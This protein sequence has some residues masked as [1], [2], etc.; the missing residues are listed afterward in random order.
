MNAQ[1]GIYCITHRASGKRYVGQAVD[2]HRRT[3]RHKNPKR[4]NHHAIGLAVLKY[5]ADAFDFAVLE[6]CQRNSLNEREAY[7]IGE[8]K[9]L[10]PNGYNLNCGGGVHV[11]SDETREK[12]KTAWRARGPVSDET[13]A[14]LRAAGVGRLHTDESR[15]KIGAAN[16]GRASTVKG[17]ARSAE[18]RAKISKSREGHA[19][20]QATKSRL[21][22]AQIG[23]PAHNRRTIVRSDGVVSVSMA[24]AARE[25]GVSNS[26]ISAC[27]TG[28]IKR[29]KGFTFAYSGSATVSSVS[30]Q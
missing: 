16:M 10:S 20:S 9:T 11:T 25:L 26:A 13:K 23:K 7:W 14:K 29:V 19:H 5:G 6:S 21:S 30:D 3:G 27:V 2:I 1:T 24:H 28:R 15:A 4:K 17:V 22:A 18:T 8:L 12:M